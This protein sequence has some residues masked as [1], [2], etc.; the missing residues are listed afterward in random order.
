MSHSTYHGRFQ[1]AFTH[2]RDREFLALGAADELVPEHAQRL[3]HRK[4]ELEVIKAELEAAKAELEAS[5]DGDATNR[6]EIAVKLA[7]KGLTLDEL[8]AH[9]VAHKLAHSG[10]GTSQAEEGGS[11]SGQTVAQAGFHREAATSAQSRLGDSALHQDTLCTSLRL[12]EAAFDTGIAAG[13]R[14]SEILSA[15]FESFAVA[16]PDRNLPELPSG[17]DK[18][19]IKNWFHDLARELEDARRKDTNVPRA[20]V[21]ELLQQVRVLTEKDKEP[22]AQAE[23]GWR[24]AD[25]WQQKA[26]E[27]QRCY[28]RLSQHCHGFMIKLGLKSPFIDENGNPR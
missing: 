26:A 23:E 12:Q 2:G 10:V 15:A 19:L 13:S 22:R 14:E 25:Y 17:S 4:T 18:Q 6:R 7:R 3:K 21:D 1:K 27:A 5:R 11:G 16:F 8:D 28:E 9:A 24:L 20:K